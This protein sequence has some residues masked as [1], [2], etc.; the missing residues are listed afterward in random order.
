[1]KSDLVFAHWNN[2]YSCMIP[3]STNTTCWSLPET[4]WVSSCLCGLQRLMKSS[5]GHYI[6]TGSLSDHSS[7][8]LTL[9][10]FW[11]TTPS[12]IIPE[13][14]DVYLDSG[15]EQ[16]FIVISVECGSENITLGFHSAGKLLLSSV[17]REIT[18]CMHSGAEKRFF[19]NAGFERSNQNTHSR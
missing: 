8:P 2:S 6:A 16:D 10:T 5:S 9:F 19:L 3:N 4:G 7:S 18:S 11:S 14:M 15:P 13:Q 17:N 1:M 12:P